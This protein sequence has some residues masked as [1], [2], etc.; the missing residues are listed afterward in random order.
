MLRQFIQGC[1]KRY[2]EHCNGIFQCGKKI[3]LN[4]EYKE[5][6]GLFLPGNGGVRLENGKLL[7]LCVRPTEVKV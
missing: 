7:R 3:G 6:R 1:C 4:S 5:K 2:K